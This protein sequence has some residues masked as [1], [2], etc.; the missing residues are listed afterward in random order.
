MARKNKSLLAQLSE[1]GTALRKKDG[2]PRA[3]VDLRTIA[4]GLAKNKER[5][6]QDMIEEAY[7]KGYQDGRDS[8]RWEGTL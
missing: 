8:I 5:M 2:M 1:K 4:E 3:Q 7:E 6:R